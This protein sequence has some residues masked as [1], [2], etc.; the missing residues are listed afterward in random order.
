MLFEALAGEV[1][2]ATRAHPVFARRSLRRLRPILVRGLAPRPEDR[3]PTMAALCERLA[4]AMR[5]RGRVRATLGLGAVT[6]MAA[7]FMT[8]RPAAERC[9]GAAR[10]SPVWN[11]EIGRASCRERVSL[12]V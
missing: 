8:L 12:N 9:D 7:G 4:A 2:G 10:A 11:E 5:P 6:A 3:H 1:P